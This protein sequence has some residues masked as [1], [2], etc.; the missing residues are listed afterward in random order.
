MLPIWQQATEQTVSSIREILKPIPDET[1][2]LKF[3]GMAL[4]LAQMGGTRFDSPTN[5]WNAYVN[6]LRI[7]VCGY[8]LHGKVFD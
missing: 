2:R 7:L 6:C 5:A 3:L 4:Q 8:A 1:V